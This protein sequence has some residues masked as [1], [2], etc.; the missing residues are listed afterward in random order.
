MARRLAESDHVIPRCTSAD[1]IACYEESTFFWGVSGYLG[2]SWFLVRKVRAPTLGCA[3]SPSP[4]YA[5]PRVK[6]LTSSCKSRPRAIRVAKYEH[7][8]IAVAFII[9]DML[10]LAFWRFKKGTEIINNQNDKILIVCSFFLL[11]LLRLGCL[12]SV[13]VASVHLLLRALCWPQPDS[14]AACE[15]LGCGRG[16]PQL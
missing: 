3:K 1:T 6:R 15:L 4:A 5:G 2:S 9:V 13:S 14:A 10:L 7:A 11:G 8:D 16:L 12:F